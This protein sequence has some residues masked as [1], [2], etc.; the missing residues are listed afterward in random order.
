MK[1]VE[2]LQGQRIAMLTLIDER[3]RMLSRPMTPQEMDDQGALWMMVSR[4]SS[5]AHLL[6][7]GRPI[8]NLAFSDERRATYVSVLGYAGLVDNLQRK[9]A[10]WSALARPWVHWGPEDPDLML[11]R[12]EP[13]QAEI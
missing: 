11:L 7:A 12:F 5:T 6:R 10:M 9:R 2:R 13:L 8:A 4:K 3:G 1:L